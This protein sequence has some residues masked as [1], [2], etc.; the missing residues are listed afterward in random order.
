MK[1]KET[2]NNKIGMNPREVANKLGCTPQNVRTMI[3]K[4]TMKAQKR[5]LYR[6][7]TGEMLFEYTISETEVARIE[8]LPI[9]ARGM[10]RGGTR[11]RKAKKPVKAG[12]KQKVQKKT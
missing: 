10:P 12:K 2:L 3:R 1:T 6:T 11:T 9:K 4:G 7:G 5:N 8:S